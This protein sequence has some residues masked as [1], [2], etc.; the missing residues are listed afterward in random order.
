MFFHMQIQ[1]AVQAQRRNYFLSI[2]SRV[3]I[4]FFF[5]NVKCNFLTVVFCKCLWFLLLTRKL[6]FSIVYR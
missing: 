5:L 1:S 6:E 2:L 4:N 3:S